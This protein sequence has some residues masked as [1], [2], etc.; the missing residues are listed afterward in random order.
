MNSPTTSS[1]DSAELL[2]PEAPKRTLALIDDDPLFTPFLADGLR[3]RGLQVTVFTDGD[4]FLTHSGAFEFDFYLVDLMLP[5]VDGLNLVR[6]IRRK[7]WAGIIVVSG[8]QDGEVFEDVMRAGADM[9]LA[10]PVRIEQV[11][12]AIDAVARRIDNARA[13]V[14]IWRLDHLTGVLTA[15][16]GTRIPLSETDRM[17]MECFLAAQGTTVTR[18][19]LCERLGR[20]PDV[21]ADNFLHA[22]IYRLRR[23]IEQAAP[24]TVPLR[25]EARVGYTFRGK[26]IAT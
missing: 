7:G 6:L 14:D 26:L 20:D 4:E 17:L 25:S 24:V 3:E 19:D 21:E 16:N 5:G 18:G 12:L 11:A 13:Q 15:P 22:A 9:H 1:H 23:R 10:K 2:E 8:R